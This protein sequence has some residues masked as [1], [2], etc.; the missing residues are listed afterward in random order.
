MPVFDSVTVRV[1]TRVYHEAVKYLTS[2]HLAMAGL[3]LV[4]F[5]VSKSPPT[6]M[7]PNQRV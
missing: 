5:I 3:T 1:L 6:V 7:N 2:V 4:T